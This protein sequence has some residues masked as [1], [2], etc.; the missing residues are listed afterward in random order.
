MAGLAALLGGWATTALL[1]RR[2]EARHCLIADRLEALGRGLDA[3]K[4]EIVRESRLSAIPS[5][6]TAL[7]RFRPA[8]A[9]SRLVT[10]SGV[11]TNVGG[12]VLCV[13]L[14]GFLG[15]L[16]A[17]LS[18]LGLLLAA[19]VGAGCGCLPVLYLRLRRA[20]RVKQFETQL[21]EAMDMISR[22]L[23][24]GQGFT[25]TLGMVAS[26][27]GDPMGT[28]FRKVTEE[29]N[30]GGGVRRALENLS[31][32]VD[33]PELRFFVVAVHIQRESGGNLAEVLDVI[34]AI[35]RKRFALLRNVRVLSAEGRLSALIL[36]LLPFAIGAILFV[37][38]PEYM[39]A[40]LGHR[41]GAW[42]LG[43]A[44]AMMAVG[45]LLMQRM[46]RIEV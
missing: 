20:R 7:R 19:A 17:H 40:L 9:L 16:G 29:I 1:F 3:S 11:R 14:L 24:A 30:Y 38:N 27:F 39:S 22:A 44:L 31:R 15:A 28:E 6:D 26:E 36:T 23:R 45:V 43:G 42:I 41:L 13:L 8:L 21:P 4:L 35:I 33:I 37:Q 34:S 2:V 46:T 12:I 25:N 32:R 10:E 5:L 18:G